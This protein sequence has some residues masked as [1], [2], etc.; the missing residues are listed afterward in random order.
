MRKDKVIMK[1]DMKGSVSR[2]TEGI[3]APCRMEL[4]FTLHPLY[5]RE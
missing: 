2:E 4:S 3:L 1:A 5:L